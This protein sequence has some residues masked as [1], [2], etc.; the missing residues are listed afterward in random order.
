MNILQNTLAGLLLGIGLGSAALANPVA[1]NTPY[2]NQSWGQQA[3]QGSGGYTQAFTAP[4]G[5]VL[6][7]IQWW[8]YHG[9]DSGGAAF[10][11]FV[12]TLGGDVQSGVLTRMAVTAADGSYLYDLYTLDVADSL[13]AATSLSII[14]DSGDV[15]WYWQSATAVGNPG[16]ASADGVAFQLLG[17]ADA[18]GPT[19]TL[20]EPASLSLVLLALTG[21]RAG[22]SRRPARA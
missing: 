15:E 3:D 18:T 19:G 4:S 6:E 11:N 5:T 2:V 20:P 14:N 10:D 13:L 7:A 16:Q 17:H 21:L 8:G 12:V 22:A 9:L 1:G